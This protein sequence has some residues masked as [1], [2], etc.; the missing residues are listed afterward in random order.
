MTQLDNFS[1]DKCCTYCTGGVAERVTY[2]YSRCE[3]CECASRGALIIGRGSNVLFGDHGYCG[4]IAVNRAYGVEFCG[5]YCK[6]ESGALTSHLSR[7]YNN[8]GRSGLEWAFGLPG[9][10]GGAIVGNA[11]AFGGCMGDCVYSITVL[12]GGKIKTLRRDECGFGYR[13]STVEGTVLG[14]VLYAPKADKANVKKKCELNLQKRKSSQPGGA[15]AGSVFKA[16]GPV[17]AGYILDRCG[18]RGLRVGG[19][20]VS[21]K[22]ANFIINTGG[23][24]SADILQL[25][26]TAEAEVFSRYGIILRREIKLIGDFF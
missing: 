6:C 9:T 19:A 22:H 26:R 23:A 5:D 16:V 3:L 18:L 8:E 13:R 21:P 25:I 17:S 2:A 15:S 20:V 14:A 11:G 7:L 1:L 24:T 12:C 4:E 10:V